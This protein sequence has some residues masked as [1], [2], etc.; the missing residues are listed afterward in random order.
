MLSLPPRAKRTVGRVAS[1]A[2]R[3]GGLFLL[4]HLK[5]PPPPAPSPP[6]FARGEGN[7]TAITKELRATL[8]I[9]TPLA[10]ANLAQ[11]AI[12]FTNTVIVGR[13]GAVPLPGA[14]AGGE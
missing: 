7:P 13:L 12:G 4:G 8:A 9:A 11:M 1:E 2:S 6:R 5:K 14:R 3:V 10:A